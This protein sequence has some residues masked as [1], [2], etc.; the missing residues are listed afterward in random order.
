MEGWSGGHGCWRLEGGPQ[1]GMVGVQ[2]ET[3]GVP[4]AGLR[5]PRAPSTAALWSCLSWLPLF[6]HGLTTPS[7]GGAFWELGG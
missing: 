1:E 2:A 6:S 3:L 7:G 5:A 4:K